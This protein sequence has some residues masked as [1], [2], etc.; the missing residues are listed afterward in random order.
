MIS[1]SKPILILPNKIPLNKIMKKSS[2]ITIIVI[3]IILIIGG[4]YFWSIGG[5]STPATTSTSLLSQSSGSASVVGADALA[6][7]NQVSTVNINSGFFSSDLF[8]SLEDLVQQ[9]PSVNMYR[10]DPFA[11]VSGVPSPFAPAGLTSGK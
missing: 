10:A 11:P 8:L 3:I 4:I 6:L 5:N 1:Q 7:L 9:V 2:L